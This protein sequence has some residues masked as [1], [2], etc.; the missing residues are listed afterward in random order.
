MQ[1]PNLVNLVSSFCIEN[2]I[3]VNFESQKVNLSKIL[4]G[5]FQQ[6]IQDYNIVKHFL[7]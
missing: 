7:S 5:P 3:T 4:Q 6:G 1:N 2:E